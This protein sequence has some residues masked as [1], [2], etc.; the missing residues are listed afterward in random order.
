MSL[1]TLL[2]GVVLAVSAPA[3]AAALPADAPTV[4]ARAPADDAPPVLTAPELQRSALLQAV[5]GQNPSLGLARAS[6]DA[7]SARVTRAR[8]L[9]DPTLRYS[10]A[11][12]SLFSDSVRFGQE[13]ELSQALPF[14]GKRRLAGEVA[15]AEATAMGEDMK[16]VRLRLA[17]LASQLYDDWVLVHRAL[18]LNAE[19][20]ALLSALKKSAEAQ[21]VAGRATQADPL[22]AEVALSELLHERSM[23]ESRRA[24]VRA[25]LNGM[26]HR[27]PHLPLPPPPAQPAEPRPTSL[28]TSEA[29][30][31][32]ALRLRPELAALRARVGGGEAAVQLASRNALPDLM[33]M[34]SYNSMWMD[35]QH[36]Y[37]AGVSLN[38]PLQLGAKRAEREEARAQLHGLKQDEARLVDEVRVE[39]EEARAMLLE[40][41]H[42]L[43]IFRE[44]VLPAA[45][46]Q[47]AAARAG[48]ATGRNGFGTVLEA[49]RSLRGAQLRLAEAR[50]DVSRR[51][52]ELQR[53]L[54]RVP[55][56]ADASEGATP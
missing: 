24:S 16:T 1:A 15:Q 30:Q 26:L 40:A 37:M 8:A 39:V 44:R 29:L 33:V 48:F 32:E 4:A 55:F 41:H 22:Q 54:G 31:A 46:D 35:T 18:E 36:Q 20:E 25:R 13:V 7:A 5:L 21:Y 42:G 6:V 9:A 23:L 12:L 11:P 43:E 14:P 56:L 47:V 3:P 19:H 53:A 45:R 28:G 2:G 10:I 52:A 27:A 49:E 50:A 38:L 34:G 17:L 51:D